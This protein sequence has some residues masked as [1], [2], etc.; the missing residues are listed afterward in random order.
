MK[1]CIFS[2]LTGKSFDQGL[3]E[4]IGKHITVA[5]A[6]ITHNGMV[7]SGLSKVETG[8]Y[9]RSFVD[10]RL[11]DES[12]AYPEITVLDDASSWQIGRKFLTHYQM[13]NFTLFQTERVCR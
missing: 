4:K 8:V 7:I 1:V 11:L 12:I 3:D 5:M 2:L 10:V 13:T 9:H 6:S